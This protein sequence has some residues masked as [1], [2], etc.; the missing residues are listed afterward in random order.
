MATALDGPG[1]RLCRGSPAL[2]P[3]PPAVLAA[4]LGLALVPGLVAL[5]VQAWGIW[6]GR[7]AAG[8]RDYASFWGSGHLLVAGAPAAAFAPQPF[9][10][11]LRLKF[12]AG[13]VTHLWSYPPT[14]LFAVWPLGFF[15]FAPGWFV[16][17]LGTLAP[18]WFA[19]A[20]AGIR[21]GW[22]LAV[23]ASPA[24]LENLIV[25]ENGALTAALLLGGLALLDRRP[26]VAG[27]LI[28]LLSIKP[29]LGFLLPLCLF[30]GGRWRSFTVAAA[31]V[32]ALTAASVG[33]F[34]LQAWEVF[35]ERIVPVMHHHLLAPYSAGYQSLMVSVFMLARAL[36]TSLGLAGLIQALATS[37][38]V[39]LA[40]R[41]W[42]DPAADPARLLAATVALGFLATPFVQD[43]DLIAL[44]AAVALRA[45]RPLKAG[46]RLGLAFLWLFPSL[47]L[48]LSMAHLP[49]LGAVAIACALPVLWRW[50]GQSG[51]CSVREEER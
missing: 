24:V 15:R 7:L 2:A 1:P 20:A 36:G 50:P 43:Y 3:A 19:L 35:F 18:L 8:L 9:A 33:V 30:A 39:A 17:T 5:F 22:R 28:G 4:F 21:G 46:G 25:G 16:W 44:I 26:A 41:L 12:G 11:W 49:P 40:W 51:L 6:Q 13:L 45:Q 27:L 32:I 47:S 29:Q 14:A 31:T 48:W 37:L 38:A 23:L 10:D 42:R 34:G